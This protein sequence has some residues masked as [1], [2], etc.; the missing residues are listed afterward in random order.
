MKKG[1]EVWKTKPRK[2]TTTTHTN[3]DMGSTFFLTHT[4]FMHTF[5]LLQSSCV[6]GAFTTLEDFVEH[7]VTEF[8]AHTLTWIVAGL[9]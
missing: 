8:S 9:L 7:K 1:N 5:S 2:K 3:S 4:H 6:K